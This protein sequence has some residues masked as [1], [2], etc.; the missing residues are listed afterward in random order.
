[1]ELL[2]L[3]LLAIPSVFLLGRLS[4][5]V[6]ISAFRTKVTSSRHKDRLSSRSS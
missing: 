1:M 6:K 5:S 4:G 3:H 2:L